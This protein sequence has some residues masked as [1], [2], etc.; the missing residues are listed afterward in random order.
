MS[1]PYSNQ[2]GPAFD[3]IRQAARLAVAVVGRER[4]PEAVDV[5]IG[6]WVSPAGVDVIA[7]VVLGLAS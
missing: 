2:G 1:A 3:A 7:N 6:K 4:V 5:L